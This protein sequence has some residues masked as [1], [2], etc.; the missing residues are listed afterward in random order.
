MGG[1]RALRARMPARCRPNNRLGDGVNVND[2]PYRTVFPYLADAPSGRDRRHI[3][4]GEA[5][6][7]AGNGPACAP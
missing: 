4:P 3:D 6:C 1:K 5:G 7:S 2:A